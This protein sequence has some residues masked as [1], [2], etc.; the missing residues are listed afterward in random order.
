MGISIFPPYPPQYAPTNSL[1]RAQGAVFVLRGIHGSNY[2]PEEPEKL[3]FYD[4]YEGEWFT[5][6]V[7]QLYYEGY[8]DG[9]RKEGNK[10]FYCPND[11]L[12]RAQATVFFLRILIGP[13]QTP[14][15]IKIPSGLLYDD[16]PLHAWYAKWVYNAREKSIVGKCEDPKNLNDNRFRPN[17]PITRAE[18]ACMMCKAMM[19]K[20]LLP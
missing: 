2:K 12:T 16:V 5:K 15:E 3:V 1:T 18:A 8:T 13:E 17:E 9:C 10:L 19:L 14:D 4:T 6:W 11:P 20:G 7:T